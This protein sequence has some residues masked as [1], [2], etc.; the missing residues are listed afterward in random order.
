MKHLKR[1]I[2]IRQYDYTQMVNRAVPALYDRSSFEP[3]TLKE[4]EQE[5]IMT[6]LSEKKSQMLLTP[7]RY[8]GDEQY[9]QYPQ[10]YLW[11]MQNYLYSKNYVNWFSDYDEDGY[12]WIQSR[13]NTPRTL[14]GWG[15]F[16][17]DYE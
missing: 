6:I 7:S 11:Q 16:E 13:K 10:S 2:I 3:I 8:K 5:Y 14:L 9:Y 12:M 17:R 15:T 4:L 1:R